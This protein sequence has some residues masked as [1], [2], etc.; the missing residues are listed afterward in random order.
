VKIET[1]STQFLGSIEVI[2]LSELRA[3]VID[4][5]TGKPTHDI[6]EGD[7]LRIIKGDQKFKK[8]IDEPQV[9]VN[10][11]EP[12][13]K[14]FTKP[15]FE[16]SKSLS[17]TESQFLNYLIQYIRF[18][19]GIIAYGN[20]KPLTR[21]NMA[22]DTGLSKKTIDRLLNSLVDKEILGKHKTGR[23]VALTVNPFIF[24]RGQKVNQTLYEFFLNSKWAKI[25]ENQN[26]ID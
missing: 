11:A 8:K 4:V 20:G 25:Y 12:F 5:K 6:N 9:S 3:Q 2:V 18:G 17:G 26:Q 16:L 7:T 21:A 22:R 14:V 19:S 24:M 15:L 10:D 1:N 13:I 23:S